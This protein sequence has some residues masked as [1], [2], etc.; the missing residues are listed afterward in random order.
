MTAW[1]FAKVVVAFPSITRTWVNDFFLIIN[2]LLHFFLSG[3][4]LSHTSSTLL[5]QDH[6]KWF[7][8]PIVTERFLTS[9]VWFFFSVSFHTMSGQQSK[10]IPTSLG[11]RLS[12]IHISEPTRP[13]YIS[14]AVFCLKKKNFFNDTAT[15][16]I[17]TVR[18]VGSVRCV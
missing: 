3:N 10:P 5:S 17:Y 8:E 6:P 7:S 16:E 1:S 11:Q 12:L 2:P 9:C 14:Y 4:Q 13:G 15:T 18:L